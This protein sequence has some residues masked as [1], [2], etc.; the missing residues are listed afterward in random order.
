MAIIFISFD[1]REKSIDAFLTALFK[2]SGILL[3][4]SDNTSSIAILVRDSQSTR[5]LMCDTNSPAISV[6]AQ[7]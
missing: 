7:K 3:S 2:K 4:D 6:N 5:E 1:L